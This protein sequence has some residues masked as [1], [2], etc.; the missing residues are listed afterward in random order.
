M[1]KFTTA[2]NNLEQRIDTFRVD[3]ERFLNGALDRP[4]DEIQ[5]RI[6]RS[7]R[8]LYSANIQSAT[9]RFRLSG[10]E[11]RFNSLSEL[12]NRRQREQE[13]AAPRRPS[14]GII[15]AAKPDASR[16]VQLQA[17]SEDDKVRALH[18]ALAERG[19][20]KLDLP[21]FQRYLDSQIRKIQN[22]TGC[23]EVSFRVAEE[24]GK[25]KLKARPVRD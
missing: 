7:I 9:E 4:P 17:G 14:S 18:S 2:I 16:G 19:G 24:D 6:R 3:W 1:A 12:F 15:H 25:L 11:A 22:K 20:M 23:A 13:G 10:L 5:E 8:H 21:E